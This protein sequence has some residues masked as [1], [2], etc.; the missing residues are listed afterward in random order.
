MST[1]LLTQ[2]RLH[3]V[4]EYSPEAGIF[5]WKVRMSNRIKVGD[6]PK[7]TTRMAMFELELIAKDIEPIV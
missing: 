6:V 3:E 7:I 4:L 1:N 2:E 5:V